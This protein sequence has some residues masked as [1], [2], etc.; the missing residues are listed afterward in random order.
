MNDSSRRPADFLER[1]YGGESLSPT[2]KS[3]YQAE[4]DAMLHSK[5]SPRKAAMGVLLLVVLL[6]C[7]AGL[8]RNMFLYD[9]KPLV[10]VAWSVLAI[11]FT[12]AAALIVRDLWLRQHTAKATF[13]IAQLL[14]GAAGTLTVVSLL[15]GMSEPANP[16]S[17]FNVLYTF[18]FYF[19]CTS[20]A[21]DGRIA[22]A[23]LA[24]RE[25]MLRIE[26]RL[27]DLAE[28]VGK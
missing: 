26:Y 22:A 14:T 25:Q 23:E 11:A 13:S 12:M 6:A 10:L 1:L 4:L 3:S 9:E 24:G 21:L 16:A 27:A 7:V 20:W 15:L 2:L 19:A 18:V 5:L 28:R 8:V 17:T